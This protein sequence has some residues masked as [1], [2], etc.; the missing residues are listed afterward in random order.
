[1][2]NARNPTPVK[3]WIELKPFVMRDA[4]AKRCVRAL[5]R[6][7][8]KVRHDADVSVLAALRRKTVATAPRVRSGR[9]GDLAFCL[10]ILF[11]L[12]SQG[13][14]LRTRNGRLYAKP[15]STIDSDP[16]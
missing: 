12:V 11:D 9:A 13:W 10:N 4:Q 6:R 1:M 15:P 14:R 3:G 16:I 8:E 7:V 2:S 5:I